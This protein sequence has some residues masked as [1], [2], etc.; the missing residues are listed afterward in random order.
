MKKQAVLR[1]NLKSDGANRHITTH[2][3][4]APRKTSRSAAITPTY[5]ASRM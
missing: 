1:R 3:V 4:A 5:G 2:K